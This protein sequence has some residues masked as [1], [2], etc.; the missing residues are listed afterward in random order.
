[1]VPPD[2]LRVSRARR[3]SG[4]RL[5]TS[6]FAYGSITLYAA[7]SQM[8][9]LASAVRYGGP[10]T[11][12]QKPDTVWAIPRSLAAT[13]GVS[14]DFLSCGYLDVSVPRVGSAEAVTALRLPGF[15]IRTSPDHR[16]L[17]RSP[18]LF[19]GSYVLHRLLLPR[20]P[21]CALSHFKSLDARC[22]F[23][24][25]HMRCRTQIPTETLCLPVHSVLQC[26]IT[27]RASGPERQ[28]ATNLSSRVES[29]WM[30]R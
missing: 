13:E 28:V 11:P 2:S 14:F 3:Y 27:I 16:V 15:P 30:S 8:L 12:H 6:T 19:A 29:T 25:H 10:T 5:P 18:K 23:T 17:A 20:H 24:G 9:P 1:M 21:P 26:K 7:S 22:V 4:Y